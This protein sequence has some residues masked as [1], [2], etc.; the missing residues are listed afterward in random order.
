MK[1][2]SGG[3]LNSLPLWLTLPL[4]LRS[5]ASGL[6]GG[7]CFPPSPQ[8]ATDGRGFSSSGVLSLLKPPV[9]WKKDGSIQEKWIHW[10][11]VIWLGSIS[12]CFS[13]WNKKVVFSL[14]LFFCWATWR[15]LRSLTRDGTRAPCTGNSVLTTGLPGKSW[16]CSLVNMIFGRKLC[17]YRSYYPYYLLLC[18]L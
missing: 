15:D 5:C 9:T 16:L 12:S 8:E 4:G 11:S 14:S 2:Y 10:S 18:S 7:I 13:N 1:S 3:C 6:G 17:L